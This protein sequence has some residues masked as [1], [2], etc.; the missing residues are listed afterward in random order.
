MQASAPFASV[1]IEKKNCPPG[2][3]SS[4]IG[5]KPPA[6]PETRISPSL[7]KKIIELWNEALSEL[8]HW[9]RLSRRHLRF[10]AHTFAAASFEECRGRELVFACSGAGCVRRSGLE[11]TSGIR[12]GL[13]EE[14]WPPAGAV[15]TFPFALQRAHKVPGSK[16][17]ARSKKRERLTASLSA[18]P[19][20]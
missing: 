2:A 5:S 12:I 18:L 19:P 6:G 20:K 16:R 8:A 14:S 17:K 11:F 15:S 9:T 10:G 4:A 13:S 3:G 1:K 7:K